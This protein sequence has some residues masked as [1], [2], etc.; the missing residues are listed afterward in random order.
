M[1]AQRSEQARLQQ[2]LIQLTEERATQEERVRQ[3][4]HNESRCSQ[5]EARACEGRLAELQQ[6]MKARDEEVLMLKMEM[7]SLRDSY[8][9]K[10]A[11]MD[12]V[13]QKYS[14]AVCEADVLRQCL[15]DARSDSS[16]LHRESELVVTNV[17]QW[18][19]EQKHTNEKLALEI[20]DQSRKIIHLTAE[21]DHLQEN[22]KGLQ[23]EIRR[24]KAELD[25]ERMEAERLK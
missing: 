17:N 6:Q 13:N 1:T 9:T 4:A 21:R 22:V 3:R 23:G 16:R 18:V 2:C 10:V 5:E 12:S 20:K 15:G 19:K 14:A 8:T 25:K 11:Q 24:L 7:G